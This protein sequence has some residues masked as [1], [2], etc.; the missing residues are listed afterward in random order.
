[1]APEIDTQFHY[2]YYDY[3]LSIFQVPEILHLLVHSFPQLYNLNLSLGKVLV[4]E[5]VQPVRD[6]TSCQIGQL[7]GRWS[8]LKVLFPWSTLLQSTVFTSSVR[9]PRKQVV[10]R[11]VTYSRFTWVCFWQHLQWNY[12]KSLA[13]SGE[14]GRGGRVSG[15]GRVVHSCPS[16]WK[17]DQAFGP[18][19]QPVLNGCELS[20][21]RECNLR[22]GSS[23]WLREVPSWRE[24]HWETPA[25]TIP[26]ARGKGFLDPE[27]SELCTT[28]SN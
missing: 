1:M 17:E 2:P 3:L 8:S 24:F 18:L 23:L 15:M 4:T 27:W 16:L 10:R 25:T 21:E 22:E 13:C 7:T 12:N 20:L 11:R 14:R 19:Y 5:S 26:A 9:F 6:K 28:A